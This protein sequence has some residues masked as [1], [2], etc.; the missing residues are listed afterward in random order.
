MVKDPPVTQETQEMWVRSLGAEGSLVEG[1]ATHSNIIAWRLPWT[2]EPGLIH[3]IAKS[4][5]Q[6]KQLSK[7]T[8]R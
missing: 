7:Q 1:M 6:V 8:S 3:R 2:V 5:T 4:Q